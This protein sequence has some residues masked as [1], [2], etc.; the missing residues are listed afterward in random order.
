MLQGSFIFFML[1]F[2]LIGFSSV[3]VRKKQS[4]D[5]LLAGRSLPP[6]LAGLSAVAT[7]NSGYMFIGVIGFT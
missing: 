6:S 5:Y 7:N 4:S 3:L 2:L 1:V